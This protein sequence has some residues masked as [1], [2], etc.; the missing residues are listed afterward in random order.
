MHND[1]PNVCFSVCEPLLGPVLSVSLTHS[2]PCVVYMLRDME[3]MED[4]YD[5]RKVSFGTLM[6][7]GDVTTHTHMYMYTHVHTH[8]H[9]AEQPLKSRGEDRKSVV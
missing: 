4:L 2:R 7:A 6:C 3:I 1:Y 9:R 5:I 8:T